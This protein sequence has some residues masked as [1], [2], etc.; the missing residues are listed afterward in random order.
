MFLIFDTETT[1]LPKR[2]NAPV[3]E[4]DNWPRVV[5]IAWQLHDG[6][7]NLI[8]HHD[9]LIRPDGFEIPYSAE[10]VHGISTRQATE[11]GIPMEEAL[12]LFN[13]SLEQS[14]FLVGH[15]IRFDINALGAEFIRKGI[16][17]KFLDKRQVCTML[18]ST[19]DLKLPGGRGGKFKPP[20]LMELYEYLF[21]EQFGEAHN[22]AADVEATARCFFELLRKKIIPPESLGITPDH[23]RQLISTKQEKIAG[24]ELSPVSNQSDPGSG[25]EPGKDPVEAPGEMEEDPEFC[26]LHVHTQYSILDGAASIPELLKKAIDDGMRAVAITDHGNMFGVKEFHNE[27]L[28]RG[29]KPILGCEAYIARRSRFIKED[30]NLDASDHIIL[31]ARN[32]EGYRNLTNLVSLGWTEGFYYKPRIDRE[33][34]EKYSRG[35]ICLSACLGGEIPQAIMH[36]TIDQAEKIVLDYKR[37]F[38]ADFYLELQRHQ[39]N[40]PGMNK[41]VF[42][43][44]VFVN[45]TLLK[46]GKKL[47]IK[48]IASNDVHFVNMNDAEAHDHLICLNTGK[49]L[50]DP[51]RMR[52]TGQ[53]WFKTQDEMKEIFLDH[54][55]VLQNTIEIADKVEIY[56]L[57]S[58]PVMPF[59]PLPEGFKNED[60]YLKHLAYEGATKRYGNLSGEIRERLDFELG[61]IQRMGF[62]GYFLIV[63]DFIAAARKMGVSVGPGRGS[64]AGSAVAYCLGITDIDP[65]K[66]D[67]LFERFLNPDRISMPDIDID[68]DEDGRDEVLHWV[69]NK[70]GHDRV[71]HIITFGTMAAKMAIRDVAR[72][73]KL[74]LP[75][76]DRLAKMVPERPGMT[77][78]KAYEEVPELKAE[79]NSSNPL[80]SNTLRIAERL[81]GSVRQTGLHACG[82]IIGRDNLT[83]HLPV[84]KTKESD[85]LVTQFDGHFVEDVGM[86]KMDFL[87][88]K[89]LSIIK[90]AIANIRDSKGIEIDIDHIPMDDIPTFE[91]YSR[92]ET[93]GLFQF[94]SPGM[95]K[96]LKDLKPN[97]FEDLIAM[98]AL[99]RPGPMEYIP[100]FINR[101]HGKEKIEYDLPEME[102]ILKDTY[103]ITVYQEQVMLLSRKLAGFTRGEADSL[104]KAMGK[105]IK[106]MMDELKV[107]F[108]DGCLKNGIPKKKIEKIWTDWEA[109]AEYAFN[110]SHSTCYAYVSYQ[111]AHLKANYP[112]EFMAAVLSRNI[113]DI[114]KIGQFMDEC[115]RMSIQ[116]L[117]PDVNESNVRFTVNNRG[118]IRF[119]LGAIKG[120]GENAVRSI[121]EERVKNGP[122]R[123]IYD[124]AERNDLHQVNRKNFE[125]LAIAGALDCFSEINRSQYMDTVEEEEPTF[126]EQLIKYGNKIQFERDTPQQNLFGEISAGAIS[127]PE[128]PVV[129]EW[130]DSTKCKKEKELVGIYLTSHPLDRYKLEIESFCPNT[131][132]DL[133]DL[134]QHRGRDVIFCGMVKSVRDGVDQ[135]RNKPYLLAQLEDYTDIYNLRLKNDD[136]VNYKQ[137]FSPDV[138]LMIRANVNEWSPREE[139]NRKIYSL[140]I[141]M[142]YMLADVREKL[143]R[144]VDL[145]IDI[146]RINRE[147]IEEIERYT[148]SENGKELKFQVHDPDSQMKVNLF[149]RKKQVAL[150]DEF[151][152]Y[153][154]G[155]TGF[156]F[157][158]S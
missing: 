97:R 43:D 46:L 152:G 95:K 8:H 62:P 10:K 19:D 25:D 145:I 102:E 20:K 61:T 63:Q 53:E 18:A 146:H 141:K 132:H 22:A 1:G 118:D 13:Q 48:C 81:E 138:A 84:C 74:P 92:G 17:T 121:I 64:A 142:I 65:I 87:G 5:Q 143:V 124:F 14:D 140:K 130:D 54:P 122:F 79:R 123:D 78:E 91:L 109:F 149:S 23:Y 114:K 3:N 131:L 127:K 110:K 105:K 133:T 52:Y 16:E 86:L 71:A 38:G 106:K 154:Q 115:R 75:E 42:D 32:L 77:F 21:G 15:N 37:I 126:I 85:L 6:S 94:E 119:G 2:D 157:R 51:K 39:S 7:G 73:Q 55:E 59:F 30:K 147:L 101:K 108:E 66:Y 82:V 88:L 98:N 93:T 34:L 135:W 153:L 41:L 60:T 27:A 158:F 9:F 148:V 150:T 33:L 45:R 4:V 70:Y 49:D 104:R 89:T 117:G 67:L 151:M 36:R 56:E 99:Y 44:Q 83:Q 58:N 28:K 24:T 129:N 111:T 35:L 144:S 116:V 137:F 47:G 107:K 136:Y 26:H 80:I 125:G 96:Y 90:D 29:V 155:N 139:P 156:D 68:F 113:T 76:A 50:E 11:Q 128:P 120:V 103:G 72:I 57:N 40:D 69:V 12:E 100:R 134:Q 112:A 31:L